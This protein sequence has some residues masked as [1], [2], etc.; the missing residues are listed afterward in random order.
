MVASTS[1]ASSSAAAGLIASL[2]AGSGM[3]T[4]DLAKNLVEAERAP[5]QKLLDD[6]I[7]ATKAEI[8]GYAGLMFV[9]TEV[10]KAFEDLNDSTDFQGLNIKNSQPNAFDVITTASAEPG[11][12]DIS[13]TRVAKAQRSLADAGYAD[14]NSTVISGADFTINLN[15][16]SAASVPITVPANSTLE[17]VKDA[18][19]SANAGVSAQVIDSGVVGAA[20]RYKLM[21]TGKVGSANSFTLNSSIAAI[22]FTTDGTTGLPTNTLQTATNALVN[23]DG[24]SYSRGSNSL[25]DVLPGVTLDLLTETT[26]TSAS[27][28]LTR[29][30]TALKTKLDKVVST[31][32]DF[33]SFVKMSTDKKSTDPDFGGVFANNSIA[34]SMQSKMRQLIFGTAAVDSNASI[35]GLRDLGLK[36]QDDGT[37]SLDATTFD[38]NSTAHY[39]QTVTMLSGRNLKNEHGATATGVAMSITSWI[40]TTISARGPLL[41]G[42]QTAETRVTAYEAQLTKL[43]TRMDSLLSRYTKQ[44]SAMD[45]I[46]GNTKSLKSSLTST[47]DGMMQMYKK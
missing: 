36:L 22:S 42:S 46:V 11:L 47:F 7:A 19:N 41:Q 44:F 13:V 15:V 16:G 29:D 34:R 14:K 3:N 33:Q 28:Q 21:V 27:I 26:G 9:I 5:Q 38:K 32:N 4:Q 2:G 35:R 17:G 23:V 6:K 18:I 37:L 12:H 43:Q 20:D 31:Y 40:G 39:D 25:S 1:S 45:A 8:T 24:V 10:K 30:T